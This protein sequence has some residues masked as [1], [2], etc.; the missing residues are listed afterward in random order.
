MAGT[1]EAN[2]RSGGAGP[3]SIRLF[4]V[5]IPL[6]QIHGASH[7]T[8]SL[9][10]VVLIE[11][12]AE[13][14]VVGWGECSTLSGSGYATETTDEAWHSLVEVLG[15]DA[16]TTRQA[17]S[18]QS[19]DHTGAA[20][21]LRDARLDAGLCEQGVSLAAHLGGTYESMPRCAVIA[22][23]GESPQVIARRDRKSVV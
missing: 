14:G 15:P 22:A 5:A 13:S 1:G 9:R 8:E 21:A 3:I 18:A 10:E 16:L 17:G 19:L 7:G 12:T 20:A 23:V 11:W 4:R 2:P 6:I